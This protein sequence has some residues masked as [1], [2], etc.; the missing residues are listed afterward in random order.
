MT[1]CSDPP[2]ALTTLLPPVR[3]RR[4]IGIRT[5]TDISRPL[6][7]Q[8]RNVGEVVSSALGDPGFGT[9]PPIRFRLNG[10]I[11]PIY[12]AVCTSCLVALDLD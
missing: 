1:S 10:H 2:S 4:T 7:R 12:V 9:Q 5:A 8:G 3:V 11:G 6:S